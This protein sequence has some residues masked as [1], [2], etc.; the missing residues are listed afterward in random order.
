MLY[1]VF[2]QALSLLLDLFTNTH[3][4]N[5]EKD[6]Q[7]LLLRQQIRILQRRQAQ[8]PRLC[9]WEK[10]VLAVLTVRLKS[11]TQEAGKRLDE[12]MLL[13]KPDTV[14]RWHRKLVRRKWTYQ[15]RGLPGRPRLTPE[16]EELIVRLARENPRWGYG[17]IQGELLKL[18]YTAGRSTVRDVLKRN[19]I[20]PTNRR[21]MRGNNWRTFLSHYADQMLACDFFT[22]ETIRL[23]TLYV[24]VFIELGT[25]RVHLAGCT[26]HPTSAWVTQQA[27]NIAWDLQDIRPIGELRQVRE[28]RDGQ[29]PIRFL[30]H[31]RDSKFTLSLD[32]VFVSE[33]VEIIRTPYRAP[34]ANAFAE[35][36]VRTVREECLDHLLILSER[37]LRRVLS[38]YVQYYNHRRPHQGIGQRIP[39]IPISLSENPTSLSAPVHRRDVLGGIIHDYYHDDCQAA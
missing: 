23:H 24:L 9:R 38:E 28:V 6:V 15:R 25:R 27:R 12:T 32:T 30:I 39:V 34:N 13:F 18:G 4:S 16:L 11:L 19:H 22:V 17:K 29:A 21:V 35:R 3:L 36:W 2:A 14:L 26:V 1:F 5:H 33:G 20:P 7:I 37:H 8:P 10:S 31:D